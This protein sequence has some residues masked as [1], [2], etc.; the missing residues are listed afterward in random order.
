[1]A[2]VVN[3][4]RVRK[5]RARDEKSRSAD[6]NAVKFGRTKGEKAR[7]KLTEKQTARIVDQHRLDD[8]TTP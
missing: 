7:D 1:M 6:A 2:K 4:S 3:L 5:S 8:P